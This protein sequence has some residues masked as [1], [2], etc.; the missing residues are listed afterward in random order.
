[1]RAS[2]SPNLALA[3]RHIWPYLRAELDQPS[4]ALLAIV[5]RSGDL[6]QQ[7]FLR[8]FERTTELLVRHPALEWCE[9][10]TPADVIERLTASRK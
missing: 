7:R 4:T 3:S 1:M 10:T 2:R 9:F 8:N 6:A 5:F